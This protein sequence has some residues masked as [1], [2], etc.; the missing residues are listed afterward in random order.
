MADDVY[1]HGLDNVLG[2]LSEL[3]DR[4]QRNIVRRAM[5]AGARVIANDAKERA[6]QI[7]DPA[8]SESIAK[9]IAVQ[10][11]SRLGRIH[12]GV[13][14]SI[15]VRGGSANYA[16]TKQNKRLGRVGQAYKTGGDK[17]NPGGDTWYWRFQEFGTSKQSARPFMRPA[18]NAKGQEA[19]DK[20]AEIMQDGI[21]KELLK[22]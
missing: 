13:A 17:T 4:I 6:K 9:N 3:P 8:T 7:D 16:G 1:L 5:R 21:D 14:M 22:P 11:R 15:G 12:G 20:V 2:Q 18:M 19:F 10:A